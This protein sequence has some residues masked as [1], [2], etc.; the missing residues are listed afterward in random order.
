MTGSSRERGLSIESSVASEE[1]TCFDCFIREREGILRAIWRVSSSFSLGL[2]KVSFSFSLGSFFSLSFPLDFVREPLEDFSRFFPEGERLTP[3][4]S[5]EVD[6]FLDFLLPFSS[7]LVIESLLPDFFFFS[8]PPFSGDFL[9]NSSVEEDFSFSFS[10]S[11]SFPFGA[12]DPWLF[13]SGVP[14]SWGGVSGVELPSPSS[15]TDFRRGLSSERGVILSFFP[16][17]MLE[18]DLAREKKPFF[19]LDSFLRSSSD[20]LFLSF[21]FFSLLRG[22]RGGEKKKGDRGGERR[23]VQRTT[24]EKYITQ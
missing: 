2:V 12:G 4:E 11:F 17:P 5:F 8:S 18:R 14:L 20:I 24:T 21:F 9:F 6:L 19:F 1:R 3:S 23:R 15:P 10:F 22:G 7:L 13:E 16:P